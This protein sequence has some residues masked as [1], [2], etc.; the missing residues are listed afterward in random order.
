MCPRDTKFVVL[1]Q[2]F[3]P[4]MHKQQQC[5][6][7]IFHQSIFSLC[8]NV[9]IYCSLLNFNEW[10]PLLLITDSHDSIFIDF[11]SVHLKNINEELHLKY[12]RCKTGQRNFKL[13]LL[14]LCYFNNF[15]KNSFLIIRAGGSDEMPTVKQ[16]HHRGFLMMMLY[17][18]ATNIILIKWSQKRLNHY[19]FIKHMP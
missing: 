10:P 11:Q 17:K 7:K 6:V 13:S 3:T 15:L 8:V 18:D 9:T 16:S 2:Y 4:R 19:M 1:F 5:N 14:M 12:H